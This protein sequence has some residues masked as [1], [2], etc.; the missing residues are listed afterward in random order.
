MAKLAIDQSTL[1]CT[2]ISKIVEQGFAPTVDDLCSQFSAS[3]D[4]VINGLTALAHN[5]GVVLHPKTSEI[6]VIHPFSLAPTNFCLES[7]R[8]KWWANCVWC[9]LGAA[10]LLQSNVSITTTLGGETRQVQLRIVNGELLDKEFLIHF[11]VPMNRSWDNVIFTCS[12]MCLFESIESID[13]WCLRHNI[14]KGDVQPVE[15][16]WRFSRAW[17][18]NHLSPSWTK[19]TSSEASALFEQFELTGRIWDLERT[20]GRF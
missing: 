6:W 17:Y 18:G 14:A 13:S 4:R 3:R 1:H 5:H 10:A 8:G 19:W 15:K 7:S 20:D 11:P 2:I 9:S 12:V 16:I